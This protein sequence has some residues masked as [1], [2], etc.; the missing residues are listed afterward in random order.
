MRKLSSEEIIRCIQSREEFEATATDTG[1]RI[2]VGH[3]VPFVGMAIHTGSKVRE[4]LEVKCALDDYQR[5]YEEDPDTDAFIGSMPI[6]IVGTDSRFAYDLNRAPEDAIYTEAWGQKVWRRA[7]TKSEKHR[8]LERHARF[9]EVVKALMQALTE[10]FKGAVVYDMHSYNK[11]RWDRPVPTF[12]LGTER[13]DAKWADDVEAFDAL[14]GAMELPNGIPSTH[15]INDV[16]M[17]RGYNL[18]FITREFDNV[19][20]LATEVAKVYCDEDSG[21]RFPLVVRALS[22]GFREAILA[23]ANA[24]AEKHTTWKSGPSSH[25]LPP[26]AHSSVQTIDAKLFGL[27]RDF[28]LLNYVNPTNAPQQKRRFFESRGTVQ[29]DFT[30]RPIKISPTDMKRQLLR[31]EVERIHDPL[32][33]RLYEDAIEAYLDKVDLLASL[34][35]SAFKYNSLRYYGQPSDQDLANARFLLHLPEVE[36]FHPV[37]RMS[38]ADAKQAFK[39]GMDAYG[40]KG[41]V[42]VSTRIVA[43]AM[44]VNAE[45]KVLIRKGATFRPKELRYLVHHEIG[46]HMVTTMNARLQPLK[47]LRIG[48]AMSTKT[49]E[50]LAVL[51]EYLSG[52]TTLRRLKELAARVV[53]V[54]MMVRGADFVETYRHLT[55]QVHMKPDDAW[56]LTTR[57]Y[58]G[59]GFTKDHLYLQGFREVVTL[60]KS[61]ADLSPLLIGK[62]SMAHYESLSEL[63]QRGVLDAPTYR[64]MPIMVPQVEKNDPIFEYIVKGIQ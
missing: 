59:G 17:G 53:A 61:G 57:V 33:R 45:Q 39:E 41:K 51:A 20:V 8:S 25:M 49:Q 19:L 62:T 11:N 14:L 55:T 32:I 60:W 2:R 4:E 22:E 35:T 7:L 56:T 24:F 40:F 52:N 43:D 13:L 46:V 48:T 31:L 64:T 9:Y 30:Y 50:G 23:H 15:G 36:T 6:T 1:L 38:V 5:W 10:D 21:E 37:K 18:A 42:Q 63:I 16:F 12:N 44:V 54:D 47:L 3:Y 27:V 29:P 26:E 58:R 34:G 28:E